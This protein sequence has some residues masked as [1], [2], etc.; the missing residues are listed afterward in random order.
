MKVCVLLSSYNGE[1]Y[2]EEQ[3]ESIVAQEDVEVDILVRDDGSTDRTC[4]ILDRWQER[5]QLRWYKERNLGFA[6]S[7]IDL[8]LHAPESDYYAFCDQDDIWLPDKLKRA[9]C[10]LEEIDNP[11]KL[12]CSNVYYYKDGQTFGAIHTAIPYYDKYTCLL[13]N[14][15]PGCSMVFSKEL[16]NLIVS[17]PP[18]EIIAHDFW[19]FQLAVLM[20]EVVYDFEPSMLYRQHENNQ[21]GQKT[22]RKDIWMRR[23]KNLCSVSHRHD[24]EEQAKEL[25]SCHSSDF[26]EEVNVVVTMIADYRHSVR[27]KARLLFD[28]RYSMGT[29]KADL[30]L[31]LRILLSML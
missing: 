27:N 1:K 19:I 26:T 18:R 13:R 23:L 2:I 3:L 10:K 22:S 17:A 16:K 29:L 7:F 12:Y 14:I 30:Y 21:I 5:G 9:A 8:V 24:R 11:V 4:E 15:A 20:G 28:N 6:L 31:K 25:L